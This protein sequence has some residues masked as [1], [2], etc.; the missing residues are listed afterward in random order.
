MSSRGIEPARSC[1]YGHTDRHSVTDEH[2]DTVS[3]CHAASRR[4]VGQLPQ[5]GSPALL[6]TAS[7]QPVTTLLFADARGGCEAS[8]VAVIRG[9]AWFVYI[10]GAPGA[11]NAAFP[12]DPDAQMPFFLRC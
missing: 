6:V 5:R 1:V 8:A 4:M 3:D 12:P 2:R 11:V 9:G 7:S 10:P